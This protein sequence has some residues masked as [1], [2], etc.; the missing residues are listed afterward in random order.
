MYYIDKTEKTF[1]KDYLRDRGGKSMSS[2]EEERERE[3]NM[4]PDPRTP[5]P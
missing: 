3:H 5:G 4:R 2:G 1:F